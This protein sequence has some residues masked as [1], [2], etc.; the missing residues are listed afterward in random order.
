VIQLVIWLVVA[1]T[2]ELLVA[3]SRPA[4]SRTSSATLVACSQIK[5]TIGW[6]RNWEAAPSDR[7]VYIY[8]D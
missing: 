7:F 2:R 5:G 6:S 3:T 8:G 1:H 4:R